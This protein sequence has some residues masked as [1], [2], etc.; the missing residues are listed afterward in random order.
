MKYYPKAVCLKKQQ[1]FINLTQGGHLVDKY[2]RELMRL[3]RFTLSLVDTE[4]KMTYNFF[5]FW[6]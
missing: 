3:K 5:F 1:K 6:A 4:Q 2:D